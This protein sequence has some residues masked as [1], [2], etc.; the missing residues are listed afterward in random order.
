MQHDLLT[1]VFGDVPHGLRVLAYFLER[2]MYPYR[3]NIVAQILKLDEDEVGLAL[4]FYVRKEYIIK[5]GKG[6]VLNHSNPFV[7][8]IMKC[9]EL[10]GDAYY[11][12]RVAPGIEIES[13]YFK[14]YP[15]NKRNDKCIVCGKGRDAPGH[16]LWRGANGG[17]NLRD[18]RVGTD[19]S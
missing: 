17:K 7:R 14:R 5:S 2:P 13:H 4:T 10:L 6:F 1:E 12:A 16:K 18:E 15:A 9:M 8:S 19:K 11:E 3:K